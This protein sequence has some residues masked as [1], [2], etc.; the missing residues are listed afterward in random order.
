MTSLTESFTDA[1]NKELTMKEVD[2]GALMENADNIARRDIRINGHAWKAHRYYYNAMKAFK[3]DAIESFSIACEI[4]I[5]GEGYDG[6]V[7]IHRD[8]RIYPMMRKSF[9]KIY[10]G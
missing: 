9:D 6:V 10:G 5:D 4:I 1:D 2:Y 3:N 7:M 8:G